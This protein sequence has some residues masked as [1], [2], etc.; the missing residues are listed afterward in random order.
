MKN[1]PDTVRFVAART[2]RAPWI[3]RVLR[4]REL[5]GMS[6]MAFSLAIGAKRNFVTDLENSPNRGPESTTSYAKFQAIVDLAEEKGIRGVTVDWLANG[7]GP[8]PDGVSPDH[9]S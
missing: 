4:V 5:T 1:C 7:K 3:P 8:G 2:E 9:G 6:R